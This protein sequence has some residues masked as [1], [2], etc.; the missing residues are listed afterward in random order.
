M[1]LIRI[2]IAFIGLSILVSPAPSF[3]QQA[4][5]IAVVNS[6]RAFELCKDAKA[7]VGKDQIAQFDIIQQIRNGMLDVIT[8]IAR[9]RGYDFVFDKSSSGVIF[10]NPLHDITDEVVRRY[11][12]KRRLASG[13]NASEPMRLLSAKAL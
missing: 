7:V 13:A 5:R 4:H 2:G 9:E 3:A 1:N 10:F 12:E 6:Q 8:D 11:N